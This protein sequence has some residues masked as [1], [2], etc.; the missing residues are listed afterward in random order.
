MRKSFQLEIPLRTLFELGLA[1]HIKQ[2][3]DGFNVAS[4]VVTRIERDDVEQLL[5][6]LDELSAE[7]DALLSDMLAES[8]V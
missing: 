5:P 3:R 1:S 6:K 7:V 8:E 2:N 4:G